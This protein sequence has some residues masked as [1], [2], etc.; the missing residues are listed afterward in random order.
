MPARD[1]N[2]EEFVQ[3][4]PRFRERIVV[5]LGAGASVG[6][7]NVDS[8]PLPNAYE[9][10]NSLWEEFKADRTRPFDP[11]ELRLMSLEHAAAIIETS[12][13]RDEVN[14]FLLKQFTC[15]KPLWQHLV[16][17]HLSPLSIFTTN[18]DEMVEL[19]YKC[20]GPVPDIVCD[21]RDVPS[22]R[23]A[24]YKPHG[25]LGHSNRKV[26]E[27]GLV[28]T[29]FDYFSMI[30]EYRKML[31]KSLAPLGEACVLIA[32]YSFGDMDIGAELFALRKEY[33]GTPWYTVFPRTDPQVRQMYSQ[34]LNIRQIG[35]TL[36]GFLSEL[37]KRV[38]FIPAPHNYSK[39]GSLKSR[40][41]IQ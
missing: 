26:G 28:I 9:L 13:G 32:G 2:F 29:Q 39:R 15:D 1:E 18:Y 23:Q 17:P 30:S 10:R 40:G 21:G 36:E 6:A 33:P 35:M 11:A 16:L 22:G 24:I 14:K 37:D 20:H 34:R 38:G 3:N 12:T 19:G 41:I 31:K 25:S 8:V 7:L 4:W 27:G 5:F